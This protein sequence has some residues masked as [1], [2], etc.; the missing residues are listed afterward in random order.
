MSLL[1]ALLLD[2]PRI[3]I[4]LA[5]RTDSIAGTGAQD[6]TRGRASRR[7]RGDIGSG[8]GAIWHTVTNT[9]S[10][11]HFFPEESAGSAAFQRLIGDLVQPFQS[12]TSQV[13]LAKPQQTSPTNNTCHYSTH[14]FWTLTA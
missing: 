13:I 6:N 11:R 4:W 8:G 10:P 12:A 14:Y 9:A 7:E 3:N 5:K 2:P 1:E